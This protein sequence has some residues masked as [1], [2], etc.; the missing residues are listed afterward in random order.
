MVI[1]DQKIPRVELFNRL[2]KLMLLRVVIV[3]I[4]LGV[5]IFIQVRETRTYFGDIQTSHYFIIA[6][7]YFATFIYIFFLGR[8]QNLTLMAYTQL[9]VDTFFI[10]AIIYTTGGIESFFSFLYLLTLIFSSSI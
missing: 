9:I 8:L 5:L 1:F 6:T 4:L 7:I 10:T 3:S 2:Q